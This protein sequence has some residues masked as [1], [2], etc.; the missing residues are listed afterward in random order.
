MEDDLHVKYRL[1]SPVQFELL[2]LTVEI[3]CSEKYVARE[4]QL[5]PSMS[6]L[7]LTS[8]VPAPKRETVLEIKIEG[9]FFPFREGTNPGFGKIVHKYELLNESKR[10]KSTT[11]TAFN[12]MA[13]TKICAA[14]NPLEIDILS[15]EQ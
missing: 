8:V 5:N 12:C 11:L 9:E 10:I 14:R 6:R 15:F 2:N 7:N 3:N 4:T 1:P 13:A